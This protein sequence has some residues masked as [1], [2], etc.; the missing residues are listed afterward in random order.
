MRLAKRP[1]FYIQSSGSLMPFFDPDT[2]LLY[3]AGKGDCNIRYYEIT[4]SEPL[5][6]YVDQFTGKEPQ[7]GLALCP[8]G[9]VDTSCCEV[10]RF[11]RL[12][13]NKLEPVSFTVPRKSDTGNDDLYPPTFA[14]KPALTAGEWS[15]GQNAAPLLTPL[16]EA[17]K[18]A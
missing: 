13:D 18:A 7:R 16:A 4:E 15:A 17:G 5:I 2:N 8:K 3:V 12:C 14:G 10:A 9:V 11:L 6:H 1:L